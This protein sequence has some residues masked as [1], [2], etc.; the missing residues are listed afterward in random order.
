MY[1]A[2]VK[3]S[4]PG[5]LCDQGIHLELRWNT[6][7]V[8]PELGLKVTSRKLARLALDAL[9]P[10]PTLAIAPSVSCNDQA[11]RLTRV[12]PSLDTPHKLRSQHEFGSIISLSPFPSFPHLPLG[13]P[14]SDLSIEVR[15]R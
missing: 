15:T 1:P 7:S 5:A 4:S 12:H 14:P 13:K 8:N 10:H 2:L 6:R 9:M 11:R 3:L